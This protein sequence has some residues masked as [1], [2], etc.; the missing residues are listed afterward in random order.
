MSVIDNIKNV[1][2]EFVEN[3][4]NVNDLKP[5]DRIYDYIKDSKIMGDDGKK[6]TVDEKFIRAGFPRD[7]LY[8]LRNKVVSGVKEYLS[9]GGSFHVERKTLPFYKDLK[10]YVRAYK[11]EEEDDIS[12]DEAMKEL[13]FNNYSTIYYKYAKIMDLKNY[14]DKAGFVDGYRKD[15]VMK[16]YIHQASKQLNVPIAIIVALIGDQNLN[17]YSLDVDFI[18]ETKNEI[19]KELEKSK[20][21]AAFLGDQSLVDDVTLENLK[22]TNLKLYNRFIY[23]K[24]RMISVF[25]GDVDYSDVM[26]MLDLDE[27]LVKFKKVP[28]KR[29]DVEKV[30]SELN[31]V[32]KSQ[33]NKL[34]R[35]DIPDEVYRDVVRQSLKHGCYTKDLFKMY[36]IDYVD[37]ANQERFKRFTVNEYPYLNRMRNDRDFVMRR[38]FEENSNVCTEEAYEKYFQTCLD[39]YERYKD[40][41][42]NFNVDEKID[43]V[44]DLID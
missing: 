27:K 12:Y 25:G 2:S 29:F 4:G 41:I 35:K 39:I 10:S 26:Y 32:A 15:A 42:Y 38:Y 20:S 11:R 1:L 31:K 34:Y 14:Q 43:D 22:E 3:G 13:G 7:S 8:H 36:D 18:E 9:K 44:Y 37:G 21:K 28:E 33:N 16:S 19:L 40:K 24:R 30:M 23:L 5:G 17:K 6:I